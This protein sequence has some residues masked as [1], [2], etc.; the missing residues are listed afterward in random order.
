MIVRII[1]GSLNKMHL[2]KIVDNIDDLKKNY[3]YDGMKQANYDENSKNLK[4]TVSQNGEIL[5]EGTKDDNIII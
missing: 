3:F 4:A 5:K 1:V 2:N